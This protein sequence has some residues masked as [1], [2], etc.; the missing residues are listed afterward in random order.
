MDPLFLPGVMFL[1]AGLALVARSEWLKAH[2]RRHSPT[3]VEEL[4]EDDDTRA[5][6]QELLLVVATGAMMILLGLLG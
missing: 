1:G 6:R 5:I 3:L 4:A 2:L